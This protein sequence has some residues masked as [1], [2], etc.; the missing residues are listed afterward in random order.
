MSIYSGFATRN[1]ESVYNRGVCQL[2]HLFQ[3]SLVS[4]LTNSMIKLENLN[5]DN[6]T[7]SFNKLFRSLKSL[8]QHKHLEPKFSEF[9]LDLAAHLGYEK[10]NISQGHQSHTTINSDLDF[11]ILN[12]VLAY[13][14]SRL[15]PTKVQKRRINPMIHNK[16]SRQGGEDSRRASRKLLNIQERPPRTSSTRVTP[17][18]LESGSTRSHKSA[19]KSRK[20]RKVDPAQLYHDQ[21]M[22][23]IY[24]SIER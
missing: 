3:R 7:R 20:T 2:L 16:L 11:H 19:S 12:D 23:L 4:V 14:N 5:T 22:S 6:L 17:N 24:S 10:A 8:E 18:I 1:Q 15:A 21:A 9:C 13:D